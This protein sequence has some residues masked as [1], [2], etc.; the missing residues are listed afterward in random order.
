ML[1]SYALGCNTEVTCISRIV[2]EAQSQGHFIN[3]PAYIKGLLKGC[4]QTHAS[5]RFP[6]L[7]RMLAEMRKWVDTI[8]GGGPFPGT[9]APAPIPKREA[10]D[11]LH[12]HT[13]ICPSCSGVSLPLARAPGILSNNCLFTGHQGLLLKNCLEAAHD[14][15]PAQTAVNVVVHHA[16]SRPVYFNMHVSN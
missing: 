8:G 7:R 16:V 5:A 15:Y 14:K 2:A 9:K 12:Q 4:S 13:M 1:F 10:L 11:R 3:S 6:G